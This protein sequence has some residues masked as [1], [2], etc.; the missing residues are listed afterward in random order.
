ME[1]YDT[2]MEM[3]KDAMKDL[4]IDLLVVYSSNRVAISIP[5]YLYYL[6]GFR[7]LGPY[8][9][10]FVNVNGEDELFVSSVVEAIRA[11][12][13]SSV[14]KINV[15]DNPAEAIVSYI[16]SSN[17]PSSRVAMVGADIHMEESLRDEISRKLGYII[18][19]GEI[20]FEKVPIS[21][22]E[23]EL[24]KHVAGIADKEFKTVFELL[25]PGMT[26]YEL[27][28]EF[29]YVARV[30]GADDNFTLLSSGRHNTAMHEP[31]DRRLQKGDIII[32][33]LSPSKKGM[34]TQICRTIVLGDVPKIVYEKY[35]ILQ[36]AL[37][38]SLM[39]VK[40]G[41]L[42][43]EIVK[44][45][46]HVISE[47]GYAEYCKPPYMRTR[48]HGFGIAYNP[49][50][51]ALSENSNVPLKEGMSL[52]VHPNQYLPETGYLAL[53]DPILVTKNGYER[54]TKLD[55]IIYSK[56]VD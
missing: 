18:K 36:R 19:G 32:F 52:V 21:E 27:S 17:V 46:N 41:T 34:A 43:S 53:G 54:L 4:G 42:A 51:M 20:I 9:L 3:I 13:E 31:T 26:E 23:R 14:N 45:Q 28:A 15:T 6:S 48:G 56:E 33:E 30:N 8:A 38:E 12:D 49:I 50:G 44:I 5:S 55:P 40:P 11:K 2:R 22:E 10:M 25:R 24:A 1:P 47:A 29:E 37:S 16:K 39:I 35:K 7:T